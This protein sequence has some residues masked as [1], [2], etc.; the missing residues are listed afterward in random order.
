[1]H[2]ITDPLTSLTRSSKGHVAPSLGDFRVVAFDDGVTYWG[3]SVAVCTEWDLSLLRLQPRVVPKK[4]NRKRGR[5]KGPVF[6]YVDLSPKPPV[7]KDRLY[8]VGQPG[9][10]RGERLEVR[11]S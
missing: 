3:E 11:S 5:S 8:C 1:M 4:G 6:P 2:A 9:R 7:P 10:P